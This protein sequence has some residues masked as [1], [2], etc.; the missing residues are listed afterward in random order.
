M[1]NEPVCLRLVHTDNEPP[2]RG[3]SIGPLWPPTLASRLGRT[4]PCSPE[5]IAYFKHTCLPLI[6]EHAVVSN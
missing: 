4:L 2:R 5:K 6:L 3:V 1:T